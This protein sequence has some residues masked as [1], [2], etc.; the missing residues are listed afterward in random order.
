MRSLRKSLANINVKVP[1][2]SKPMEEATFH[3][4]IAYLDNLATV[5]QAV[6]KLLG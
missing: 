5:K 2:K 1:S 6:I 4:L 3:R